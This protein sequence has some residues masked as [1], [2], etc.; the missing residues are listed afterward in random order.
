MAKKKTQ[1]TSKMAVDKKELKVETL[2]N[3]ALSGGIGEIGLTRITPM[4]IPKYLLMHPALPRGVDLKANRMVKL[5]DEDLIDNVVINPSFTSTAEEVVNY[6]RK[7]LYDS[8]GGV[9]VKK[10]I[11]EGYSFGT[12]FSILQTNK[13][14]T[15]VLRFEYQHPIF[16]GP[17]RYPEKLKGTNVE[18]GG[19]PMVDRHNLV[20][21]IKIDPRTKLIAKYTQLTKKY[22]ERQESNLLNSTPTYVNTQTHPELKSS[23]PGPLIPVGEEFDNDQVIQLMFNTLGDE[24]LGISLV[25]TLHLTIQYLLNME[26]A[27]AQSMV[28]FGFNKWIATTPFKDLKKLNQFSQSLAQIQKHS[29]I[30]L[31]EGIN[32]TNIAPGTTDFDRVHPIYMRLIAIRL[33]IPMP[34][35]SQDGEGTNKATIVE[36]RKDMY[37]DFFADEQVIEQTINDGFFKACKIKWKDLSTTQ[38]ESIVPKFKFNP[39]PEDLDAEMDRNL[40]FSL[41]IRNYATA[42]KNWLESNGDIEVITSIGKKVDRLIKKS[43]KGLAKELLKITKSEKKEEEVEETEDD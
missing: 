2:P 43:D 5:I 38:L 10:M 40:K 8:G 39:P 15:K 41:M 24:Q 25:Q 4:E 6:C 9:Y 12:T 20:G 33:G 26:K 21:K 42:A 36:M 37:E 7:I 23:T 13:A 17:A 32:L 27:G 34:L 19:M 31:P 18:W 3:P 16:F 1:E 11:S 22:P 35:L 29:V 30:S 14:E 28:N